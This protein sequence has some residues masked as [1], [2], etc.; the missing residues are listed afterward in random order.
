MNYLKNYKLF[1]NSEEFD[2]E[3]VTSKFSNEE[4]IKYFLSNGGD[5]NTQDQYGWTLLSLSVNNILTIGITK[6]KYLLENGADTN[7]QNSHKTT[8][9]MLATLNVRTT[10]YL[11]NIGLLL[12]YGADINIK[13]DKNEDY[14]EWVSKRR[15]GD[16]IIN[17]IKQDYPE[18][19]K[20]YYMNKK[21]NDFGI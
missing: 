18:L 16:S 5:I 2:P 17:M 3:I 14:I 11:T 1:E 7:I 20:K 15:T 4:Y 9:L 19:L 10:E 12:D 8:C 13:N 6:I 21:L